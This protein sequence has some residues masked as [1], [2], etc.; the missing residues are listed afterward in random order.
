[1]T[2]GGGTDAFVA[3]IDASGS[4][5][6]YSTYLGGGASDIS[7]GIAVNSGGFA[8]V[9]GRTSSFNFPL[10]LAYQIRKR[11]IWD[12]FFTKINP[13]GTAIVYSSLFGGNGNDLC[14]NEVLISSQ[15]CVLEVH[16][17]P[18]AEVFS[19]DDFDIPSN[20]PDEDPLTIAVTGTGTISTVAKIDVRDSAASNDDLKIPF[21]SVST[22]EN[23]G[24]RVTIEIWVT[25]HLLLA[26]SRKTTP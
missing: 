14:S 12:A 20:D 2:R 26:P 1:M 11:G 5:L 8:Y 10:V 9:A 13:T 3:K 4:N 23:S 17:S 16:F 24:H 25:K 18:T 7:H 6:I 15:S 21:G 19:Y 22:G